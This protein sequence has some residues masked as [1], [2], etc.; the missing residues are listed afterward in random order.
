MRNC[1]F[2][3]TDNAGGYNY[4]KEMD[5]Y[6]LIFRMIVTG[7]SIPIMGFMRMGMNNCYITYRMAVLEKCHRSEISEIEQNKNNARNRFVFPYFISQP[8][9]VL[10]KQWQ[11]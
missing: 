6:K 9:V 4:R 3:K 1:Y 8:H 11:R 10:K 7:M 5:Q 2:V